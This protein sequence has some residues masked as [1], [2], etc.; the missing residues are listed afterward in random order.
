MTRT[1]D[2]PPR[3]RPCWRAGG[4][5]TRSI[6]N[7]GGFA[8]I[9]ATEDIDEVEWEAIMASEPHQ[10]LPSS[11]KAVA[12][13]SIMKRQ[14][15]GRIVN[16]P[17]WWPAGRCAS[18]PTTRRPR[19]AS[20][21][22]RDIWRLRSARDGI[23]VNAVAPGHLTA[24]ERVLNRAHGG[25]DRA[26]AAAIPVRRLGEPREIADAVVFLAPDA[27]AFINGATLDV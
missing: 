27:A 10:R 14:R 11:P 26:V 18:P 25:G 5:W 1:P 6:N 20:S 23:T 21:A 3:W 17:R 4:A 8:V 9:R 13:P 12:L 16:W 24:T 19:R 22:S 2:T 15:C 7:A